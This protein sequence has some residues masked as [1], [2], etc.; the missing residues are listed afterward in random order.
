[1]LASANGMNECRQNF[2]EDWEALPIE[3][4]VV[5]NN[6]LTKTLDL[7]SIIRCEELKE[8]IY[9]FLISPNFCQFP[10]DAKNI[11]T[12]SKFL[13]H[14]LFEFVKKRPF[15]SW[16]IGSED[17]EDSEAEISEG[18]SDI[19]CVKHIYSICSLLAKHQISI[20]KVSC[21]SGINQCEFACLLQA[22]PSITS[23]TLSD[24]KEFMGVGDDIA[25]LISNACPALT[26]LDLYCCK[27]ITDLGIE[28]I[29]CGIKKL[30]SLKMT[31]EI[32]DNSILALSAESPNL[33]VLYLSGCTAITDVSLKA[34]SQFHISLKELN[35]SG[36]IE[37]E[38]KGLEYIAKDCSNLTYLDITACVKITD[39]GIEAIARG[40]NHLIDINI[41]CCY[42]IT[43]KAVL[44][45]AQWCS[46][47][48]CLDL[49]MCYEITND[50]IFT[51]T[52]YSNRLRLL[53]IF[54]CPHITKD[55]LKQL[56]IH[57]PSIDIIN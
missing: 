11:I 24:E 6:R 16:I 56:T 3:R 55:A 27:K 48:N 5:S 32:T 12:L 25:K 57:R 43:D 42:K 47:L 2:F 18:L 14:S 44:A 20:K 1:M 37:I 4:Q 19:Q 26:N 34:I 28:A 54:D 23:L 39:Q 38:D 22:C 45:I 10:N 40:C 31:L 7:E 50:S 51:I 41:G 49:G 35:M 33:S 53:S 15:S 46:F 21:H 17:S 52:K 9:S 29:A 8:L 36:C 13:N 30:T